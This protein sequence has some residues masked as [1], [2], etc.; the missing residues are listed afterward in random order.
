MAVPSLDARKVARELRRLG[1]RFGALP[2][3]LAPR[4]AA[5]WAAHKAAGGEA[6]YAAV[7]AE[8]PGGWDAKQVRG[9]RFA[10]FDDEGDFDGLGACCLL[11]TGRNEKAIFLD[12]CS[13]SLLPHHPTHTTAPTHQIRKLLRTNA[14]DAGGRRRRGGADDA[15]DGWASELEGGDPLLEVER[16]FL[17]DLYVRH[18]AADDYLEKVRRAGRPAAVR[19]LLSCAAAAAAAALLASVAPSSKPFPTF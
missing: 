12:A 4:L 19:I 10:L 5:L 3:W 13:S 14:L 8:L 1:L 16:A 2:P 15:D 17:E 9:W 6:A 18:L 11:L 7:A